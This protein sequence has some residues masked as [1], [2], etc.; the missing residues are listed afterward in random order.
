ME[1][2]NIAFAKNLKNLRTAK[3]L[4]QEELAEL[5]GIDYKYLQKLESQNPSSPTLS[6][7]KKLSTGLGITLTDLISHIS[8]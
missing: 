3:G 4:T 5:S 7:L 6:T 1:D 8:E 2:I